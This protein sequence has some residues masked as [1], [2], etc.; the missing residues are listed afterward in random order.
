MEKNQNILSTVD[1]M[2]L[3]CGLSLILMV[4]SII[5]HLKGT[6]DLFIARHEH[7]SRKRPLIILG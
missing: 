4:M 3:F 1:N 6:Q 2:T 5:A 7:S